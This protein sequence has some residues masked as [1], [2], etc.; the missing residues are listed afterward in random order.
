MTMVSARQMIALL[1]SLNEGDDEQFYAIALQVAATEARR[2]RVEVANEL[3]AKVDAAR[4]KK[5]AEPR[6]EV[7]RGRI[8]VPITQPRG[9]L[10]KLLTTSA[11]KTRLTNLSVATEI[12]S[13]LERFVR[14]QRSRERLRQYAKVPNSRLLLMGPPGCGKTLTAAALAGELHLPLHVIRLDSVITRFMGETAAKLRLIFDHISANRGLYLFDEFDAIGGKRTSDNDVGEMRRVLNSFLQF[15]EEENTTDSI[16]AAATNHPQLLD[17]ALFRRFDDIIEY[18]LP[19]QSLVEAFLRDKL[20]SFDTDAIEWARVS[21]CGVG[22][23]QA[24]IV[25][26]VDDVIK[27][28]IINESMTVKARSLCDALLHRKQLP[29]Q[30]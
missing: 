7:K 29:K 16:V 18:H 11:P 8:V 21:E 24:E 9:E 30:I 1:S 23:S 3:R 17:E 27:D 20:H 10:Q 12:R 5:E 6:L 19:D 22:L 25:R 15:I 2:G 14:Q 26:A 28:A 13:R 4:N